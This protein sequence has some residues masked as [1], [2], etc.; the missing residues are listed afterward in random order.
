MTLPFDLDLLAGLYISSGLLLIFG[1]WLYYDRRD[2]HRY[3]AL[4]APTLFVCL[5]CNR[6]FSRPAHTRAADCPS[7]GHPNIPLRF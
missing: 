1:L 6:I 5:K 7:C 4:R 2:R 3:D